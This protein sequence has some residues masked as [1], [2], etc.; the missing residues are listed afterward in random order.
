[1]KAIVLK[2]LVR[3]EIQ[4]LD[5]SEVG[6]EAD[7]RLRKRFSELPLRH[8]AS[9]MVQANAP[10]MLE[11]SFKAWNRVPLASFKS[12]WVV[13]G[14]FSD[15]HFEGITHRTSLD[16]LD[17]TGLW[18]NIGLRPLMGTTKWQWE[19]DSF[20]E[21]G[22][23]MPLPKLLAERV[24]KTHASHSLTRKELVVSMN[25]ASSDAHKQKVS[26][27]L[28]EHN[29]KPEYIVFNRRSNKFCN[30]AWISKNCA[31]VDGEM[32]II[33]KALGEIMALRWHPENEFDGYFTIEGEGY[34]PRILRCKAY[35]R[36]CGALGSMFEIVAFAVPACCFSVFM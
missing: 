33:T 24:Q 10:L 1:M 30:A 9:V 27:K 26:V 21:N 35:G 31:I 16:H 4:E 20:E 22:A 3:R 19:M 12:A 8:N 18:R 7:L 2:T 32:K 34:P 23:A 5:N 13:C 17:S 11:N 15:D 6:Y 25:E 28:R 14:Y 36:K 29:E